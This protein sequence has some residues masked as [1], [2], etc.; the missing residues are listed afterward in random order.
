MELEEQPADVGIKE[1]LRDTVGIFIVID[2][3]MMPPMFARPHQNRVFK[4]GSAENESEK[5]NWLARLEGKMRIKAVITEGDTE[6]RRQEHEE[7]KR[8][9]KC[10]QA[11]MP[12]IPGHNR[13]SYRERANEERACRP[14]NLFKGELASEA[15]RCLH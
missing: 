9:L 3:F 7:E 14:V 11:K 1:A 6:S 15:R 8:H 5:V 13:Q 10:I 2:M 12:E 4:S